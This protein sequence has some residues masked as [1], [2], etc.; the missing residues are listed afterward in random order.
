MAGY[1]GPQMRTP[2]GDASTLRERRLS[3]GRGVPREEARR[4]QR[5]RLFAAMVALT[6]EKGYAD[7]SVADLVELSGVSSRSFYQHFGDKEECFLATMDGILDNVQ[8]FA[9]LVL[10]GET[11]EVGRAHQ[12]VEAFV[13]MVAAQPAA[14]KLC[15]VAAFSAGE[16]PRARIVEAE[17]GLSALLH[18][19]L[20][21]LP[22]R[23]GM[24]IDLTQAILGGVAVVLYRRLAENRL[25]ELEEL[26]ARLV[27]WVLSIPPPPGPLRPRATRRRALN[28]PGPP[29]LAAHIPAER[30][31]RGFASVVAEKGYAAATIADVA[32]RARI[33]QNTFYKHFRDKADAFEALLDSSGAQMVAAVLPAVRRNPEWPGAVRVALEALCGFMAAEPDFARVREVEVYAVGAEAVAQRDRARGEIVRMV[34]TVVEPSEDFDPL[35]VEATLGAFQSLLYG[36]IANRRMQ[37]LPEVPPLVTYLGLAPAIGAEE[38][39]KVATAE[40][41]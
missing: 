22:E 34:A 26:G 25:D 9:E 38:A 41:G 16:K 19:G 1:V 35:A 29:P 40:D 24:P 13:A 18:R 11:L 20:E 14:A 23:D 27:D 28:P 39:W 8:K 4:N 32:A 37:Q 7:T 12:V 10:E 5:E 17:E 21:E 2:W 6:A 30:V 31:L 15:M 33:S 3:P 36:R